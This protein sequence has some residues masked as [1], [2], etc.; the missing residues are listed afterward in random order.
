MHNYI[1]VWIVRSTDFGDWLP[2]GIVWSINFGDFLLTG[3]VRTTDLEYCLLIGITRAIDL[4]GGLLIGMGN[5]QRGLYP[6]FFFVKRGCRPNTAAGGART[7]PRLPQIHFWRASK[8]PTDIAE[9]AHFFFY[10]SRTL[11]GLAGPRRTRG[12]RDPPFWSHVGGVCPGK[13]TKFMY[14]PRL[15]I[16][17][18]HLTEI[19]TLH[20]HVWQPP[21]QVQTQLISTHHATT[22]W[23]AQ[24][25]HNR[26]LRVVAID[27]FGK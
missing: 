25:P 17:S 7:W 8:V 16:L 26:Q 9:H 2:I 14:Y 11:L 5:G 27:F 4:E 19:I 22:A 6:L 24:G 3:F 18:P 1:L 12:G 23:T 15:T 20:D 21:K 10:F 13:S